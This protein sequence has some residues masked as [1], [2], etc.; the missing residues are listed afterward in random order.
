MGLIFDYRRYS[1]QDGPGIRTTVFFKGCPLTCVWCHN[2]ESQHSQ[3]ELIYRNHRCIHCGSCLAECPHGAIDWQS[4]QPQTDLQLCTRCGL[5]AK[6]CPAEAREIAGSQMSVDAVMAVVLRDVPFYDESNG[7][8][9]FSG[10]EPMSQVIFL[11]ELLTACREHGIH[12]ALDTCGFAPWA[13]F[14]SI[15]TLV[16]LF[17]FDLKLIDSSAH[18]RFTGVDNAL[19]LTNLQKLAAAGHNLRIRVPLIPNITAQPENLRQ[20]AAFVHALPG[21]P[22][23]D[24]L[25]Y[26][27]AAE[28]KY[29]LLKR[30]Y[31]LAGV[32]ALSPKQIDDAAALF[33]SYGLTVLV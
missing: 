1:I 2:P 24:L 30:A 11:H 15:R 5:C 16:D 25:P 31:P 32:S 33:R 17:L 28:Q 7:G 4:A 20:I 10:G 21:S 13:A 14:E 19:I 8:V 6:V 22:P 23:V 26:H 18:R 27:A 3:P 12:T 29:T 9:T